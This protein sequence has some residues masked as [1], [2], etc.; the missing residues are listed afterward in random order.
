MAPPFFIS[1]LDGGV[2]LASHSGRFTL[3]ERA[4]ST[5][6]TGDWVGPRT[7]LEAVS[8]EKSFASEGNR[9]PVGCR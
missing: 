2:W 4:P 3:G 1:A 5:H 8:R 9:I 6:L 7:G